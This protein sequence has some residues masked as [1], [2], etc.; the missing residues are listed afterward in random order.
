MKNIL[1]GNGLNIQFSGSEYLNK[2]IFERALNMLK[3]N[4]F[5]SDLYPKE[6]GQWLI[7]LFAEV[8][9]TIN[10][11][12]DKFASSSFEK[13]ALQNFKKRHKTKKIENQ[14]GHSIILMSRLYSNF[15]LTNITAC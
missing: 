9:N 12:Y 1:I 3:S 4:D 2:S 10:G 13:R 6:I 8:V 11:K 7:L 14:G 15:F 5:P